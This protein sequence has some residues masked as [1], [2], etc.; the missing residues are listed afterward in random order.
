MSCTYVSTCCEAIIILSDGRMCFVTSVQCFFCKCKGS[1]SHSFT[2]KVPALTFWQQVKL[3]V[4]LVIIF[5]IKN[6][7]FGIVG[8]ECDHIF[9]IRIMNEVYN[10][11]ILNLYH[12]HWILLLQ[13]FGIIFPRCVCLARVL[14]WHSILNFIRFTIMQNPHA[15]NI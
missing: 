10:S 7:I 4:P 6:N 9:G 13:N 2:K 1:I 5:K 8:L 12:W 14:Q 3:K 11:Q 15:L